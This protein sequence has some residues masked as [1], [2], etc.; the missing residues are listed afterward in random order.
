MRFRFEEKLTELGIS[1]ESL[2][3]KIKDEIAEI[4]EAVEDG[5][6][7]VD[8]KLLENGDDTIVTMIEKWYKGMVNLGRIKDGKLQPKKSG[9]PSSNT[10]PAQ[11]PAP[12]QNAPNT[13]SP[14]QVISQTDEPEKK[15]GGS[16]LG[17]ILTAAAVVG[18]GIFGINYF[19]NK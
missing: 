5:G 10:T 14:A 12:V 8:E 9:R 4:R 16:I 11:T 15:E 2:S 18:L 6:E 7:E 3:Q 13:P 1:E 17:T 19:K